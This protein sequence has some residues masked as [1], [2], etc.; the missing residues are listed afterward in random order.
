M[1]VKPVVAHSVNPY[2]PASGSWIYN[3]L[4]NLKRYQPVVLTKRKENLDAFPFSPVYAQYDL[5]AIKRLY[6]KLYKKITKTYFPLYKRVLVEKNAAILHSHFCNYGMEDMFLKK[7]LNLA[8]LTTFYGSDIWVGSTQRGWKDRFKKFAESSDLFLVEG[9][10]MKEKVVSLG[11][12]KNMVKV[13]HL[14]VDL[15]NIEF[16]PRAVGDD[17]LIRILMAGR[18]IEKKGHI[19]GLMAFERLCRV[20]PNI[21][22]DM[23]VGGKSIK[24]E[25]IKNAMR[26]FVA[27]NGI[28]DK[29]DWVE[30][31]PYQQYLKR[32]KNAHIF[33]QP[34]VHASDGDAEGGFPVTIT[35]L[36]AS[37]VPIVGT[38][39]CDI[40]EVVIEGKTGL[41]AKENDVDDLTRKLE[42]LVRRPELWPQFGNDGR[43]HIEKEYNIQTQVQLLEDIYDTLL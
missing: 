5:P 35:E 27:E 37:G 42:Y 10:A 33:L 28:Q 30:F 24:S 19:Y 14:G 21:R 13:F 6:E 39:H 26:K 25:E 3:Q 8:H 34:S 4:V 32:I 41:L 18:A 38:F 15:G 2:L 12:D 16:S 17:G 7:E 20:Y 1:S 11:A 36:S 22:L 31:L 43:A 40:P 29:V 23:I 9:N